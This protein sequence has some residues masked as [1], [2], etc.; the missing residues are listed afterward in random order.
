MRILGFDIAFC[1]FC[2]Q[3]YK[4]Q[5]I[6]S[7]NTFNSNYFSDGYLEG[8]FIPQI[9][10]IIK[11]VNSKCGKLFNIKNAKI[12]TQIDEFGGYEPEWEFA[13]NLA[14]YKIGIK[15]LQEALETGF[16]ENELEEITVRILL[17]YRYNDLYRQNRDFK[18]SSGE[19]ETIIDNIDKLIEL[20]KNETTTGGK[21]FLAELYREKKDFDICLEILSGISIEKESEKDI[22]EKIY[23]QAKVKD[24]IVFNIYTVAV[25][26]EYKC[27]NCNDRLILFNL[28]KLDT[29]LQ[30]KHF[31]C[32]ID[33][34]V[35]NASL[36]IQNPIT[37]YRLNKLQ[38]MFNLKKPHERFVHNNELACPICKNKNI[39]EFS[40]ELQKCIKCGVGNYETVKW[41]D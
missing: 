31:I 19:K 28:E 16:C 12:I 29:P 11:C 17:L 24:D 8:Q 9:P 4:N 5:I 27:N 14:E 18:F 23:S 7:S 30:Y 2:L 1:P 10:S 36:K 15:E 3:V 20:H 32:R 21:L 22:K 37:E 40:P 26:K 34:K 25:K 6:G 38:K 33:N 13:Y 39:Q 35:F 41:F